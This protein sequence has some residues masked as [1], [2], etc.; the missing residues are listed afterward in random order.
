[1]AENQKLANRGRV[2]AAGALRG[3]LVS[4]SLDLL[5]RFT[6][7]ALVYAQGWTFILGGTLL[8]TLVSAVIASKIPAT[9]Q[10][11]ATLIVLTP[12]LGDESSPP[13]TAS[14]FRFF[15]ENNTVANKTVKSTGLEAPPF[16]ISA[17]E[18]LRSAV[19]V[20]ELR[21]TN[22]LRI[23]VTL[24]DASKAAEAANQAA[25]AGVALSDSLPR[26]SAT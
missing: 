15:I 6:R 22:L 19:S 10:A 13:A 2:P 21:G 7:R 17:Q 8:V 16:N 20:E 9:Y 26:P 25:S 11:S 3:G 5:V 1:L 12:K 23:R 18:F 24:T 14:G 4:Q